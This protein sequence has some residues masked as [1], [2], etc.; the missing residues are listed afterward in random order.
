[1]FVASFS[2]AQQPK[3][4]ISNTPITATAVLRNDATIGSAKQGTA[5]P[6]LATIRIADAAQSA[7][8][9]NPEKTNKT[10]VSPATIR[11][12]SK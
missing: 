1:M 9:V 6:N 12:D 8:F 5:K 10:K 4:D 2:Y 7:T 11:I 3:K